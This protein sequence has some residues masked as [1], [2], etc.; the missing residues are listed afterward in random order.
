MRLTCSRT[1]C[2]LET[3]QDNKELE[4]A[5]EGEGGRE[6]NEHSERGREIYKEMRDLPGRQR[7]S[8]TKANKS[9]LNAAS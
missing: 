6:R 5:A 1:T 8:Q 4:K 3:T 9:P 7:E 2:G